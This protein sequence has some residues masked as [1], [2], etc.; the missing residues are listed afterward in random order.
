[1]AR[2]CIMSAA[3]VGRTFARLASEVIERNRGIE[4]LKILGIER[5]GTHVARKLA[6]EISKIVSSDVEVSGLDVSAFRDD[7]AGV[8]EATSQERSAEV[9]GRHVLLVDDVLQSGR[10]ARAALDAIVQLGRPLTIQFLVLIDR[11]HREYPIQPD[12]VGKLV[13]TKHRERV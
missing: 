2:T 12:Y 8:P 6:T 1:M 10:T 3:R 5:N 13:H 7:L 11:G 9:T 4:G